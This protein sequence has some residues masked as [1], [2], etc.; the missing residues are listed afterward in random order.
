[1]PGRLSPDQYWEMFSFCWLCAQRQKSKWSWVTGKTHQ[2]ASKWE[3]SLWHP[4]INIL[5][6]WIPGISVQS[7]RR[8]Q[9]WQFLHLTHLAQLRFSRTNQDS[10]EQLSA[11][12]PL[13][14]HS[15]PLTWLPWGGDGHSTWKQLRN[16]VWIKINF[17][18]DFPQLH[19]HACMW[20]PVHRSEFVQSTVLTLLFFLPSAVTSEQLQ[21]LCQLRLDKVMC[22]GSAVPL[23]PQLSNQH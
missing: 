11:Q 5:C 10:R 20:Q 16:K 17:W 3:K 6:I 13:P 23:P 4:L 12:T 7:V 19:S 14:Q 15:G 22:P 9:N 18:T 1:M 2:S 21:E 8:S